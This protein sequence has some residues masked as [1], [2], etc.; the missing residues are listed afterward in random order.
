VV[1]KLKE[2]EKSKRISDDFREASLK[3]GMER[4]EITEGI[5]DVF[6]L[7]HLL[8]MSPPEIEGIFQVW[9]RMAIKGT[10]TTEH[11][12]GELGER[13]PGSF[14]IMAKAVGVTPLVLDKMIK[15]GELLLKDI[16]SKFISEVRNQYAGNRK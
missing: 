8:K 14:I 9:T 15:K 10:I 16:F 12:R 4:T 6:E 3:L 11:L 2:M 1:L 7:S 13:L 5:V